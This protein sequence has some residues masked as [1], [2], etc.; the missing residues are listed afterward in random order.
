M[1]VLVVTLPEKGHYHPLLGPAEELRRRGAEVA[2]A[3]SSDISDELGRAGVER[4]LVPPGSAPPSDSLRGEPL[5]RL[6]LDASALHGW[7]RGLLVEEPARHVAA[8]RAILRDFSPDVVAID[9][10][11][12]E[13]AVAA[14]LE[15]VPWVGWSTSL[16]PVVP[17][18]LDSELIRTLKALDSE[19][20]ALFADYGL[21]ARFRVSDVLSPRGTATFTTEALVGEAPAGVALVGPSLG[22]HRSGDGVPLALGGRRALIYVSFGSQAW[23]QPERYRNV[24][25]AAERLGADVIAATG[26]LAETFRETDLAESIHCVGFARQLEV[27]GKASAFVTH[28]GANSVMEGLA[29]GVPLLIAPICNDQ[30]HNLHFVERA[31]AGLGIDLDGCSVDAL[32]AALERLIGDGPQRRAA[33]RVRDSYAARNG[34]AGAAE[35]ALRAAS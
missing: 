11:A 21:T 32:A 9:T 16:N 25:R 23:F 26:D 8:L 35:L 19:R 14:D 31:G 28:G 2:F 7:I 12:Y 4:V 17:E 3:V 24:F 5:A 29:A 34:S 13:G 6:L 1:R 18:N 27:L 10:M 22:G 30:P 33:R 15:G 20:H